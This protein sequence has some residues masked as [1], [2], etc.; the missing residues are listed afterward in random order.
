M[1]RWKNKVAVVTGASSGI[2][3]AIAE[4]LVNKD[5]IVVG[6]A[7]REDR[8]NEINKKLNE[9]KKLFY[10]YVADVSKEQDVLKAFKWIVTTL[11]PIHILVNNAGILRF[12]DLTNGKTKEWKEV[13]DTNVIGLC[14]TTR[15]AIKNMKENNIDGHVVHINSVAGHTVPIGTK[16]YGSS[17]YAVTALTE[18]LRQELQSQCSKIKVTSVSPGFV[19][20]NIFT[21]ALS[22]SP[23]LDHSF[24]IEN[25][26][27]SLAVLQPED[28]ADSVLYVLGTPPHV[29]VVG[30]ARGKENLEKICEKLNKNKKCFYYRIADMTKEED[31]VN[32]IEWTVNNV[33]SIHI[34]VNNAGIGTRESLMTGKTFFWKSVID[35]NVIGLCIASR[36]VIKNMNENNVNGHI[37]NINS[38]AGHRAAPLSMYTASKFAITGITETLQQELMFKKSKIKV[39]SISPGFVKTEIFINSRN[40]SSTGTDSLFNSAIIKDM[41]PEDGLKPDD[42]AGSVVYSLGTPPHVQCTTMTSMK[43]WEGKVAVVTGASA[44]IGAATTLALLKAGVIV[45]SKIFVSTYLSQVSGSSNLYA[46]KTDI[47]K[48]EDIIKAFK[49][50]K[51]NLGPVH[52][53]IN[54]A[55]IARVTN[56]HDGNTKFWKE[57]IDVNVMGLSIATRE[58]VHDMRLNNVDGHIIHINSILGHK[59]PGF[60]SLNVLSASKFAVTALTETL[61]QELNAMGSKIKISSV[62]PGITKTEAIDAA[63]LASE[64]SE[65]VTAYKNST[66]TIPNLFPEDVTDAIIY[67]LS[68]PPHVQV[69]DLWIK[70]LGEGF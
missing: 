27:S 29:Q 14:V 24:Q 13:F 46:I 39:S 63:C 41:L 34:L 6:L 5:V 3:A 31:I 48:E 66:K 65:S 9:R 20:T 10:S 56:L 40:N 11:G 30:L 26:T 62:S 60:P 1:Q 28:V 69:H 54:N 2:G 12:A 22:T 23:D 7:R 8:L 47:S 52:I 38:L 37:I 67:I 68:T 50:I 61:R 59:C 36:E 4:K 19:H 49:W 44:G 16:I 35:T 15:E 57:V 33:G 43:R 21:S 32:A 58:A 55:G 17:K 42:V 64:P 51:E 53:L 25:L 70:P 45:I 18:I